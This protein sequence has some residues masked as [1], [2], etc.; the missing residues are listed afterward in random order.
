MHLIALL[1]IL[2]LLAV[3][4][5]T[6]A[7]CALSQSPD[8]PSTH[9]RYP[10]WRYYRRWPDKPMPPRKLSFEEKILYHAELDRQLKKHKADH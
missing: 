6:A 4:F 5:V 10:L 1:I 8:Q 9:R 2:S 3:L 7:Y